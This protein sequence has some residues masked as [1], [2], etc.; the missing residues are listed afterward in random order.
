MPS[1]FPGMDPYVERP[2]I[3]PDFHD[4]L[5]VAIR[6]A[7]NPLLRP[8]YAALSR[9]RL[10]VIDS[11]R[12]VYPDVGFVELS[13]TRASGR[14]ATLEVDAPA[15]FDLSPEEVRE[16]YIE[17]IEP[18]AGNR[19]V[20]SIEVLSP[21]NKTIGDGRDSYLKKRSELWAADVNLVEIDLLRDGEPTIWVS[22]RRLD[23]LRPWHYVIAVSR[24]ERHKQEVYARPLKR[25]LPKVSIPLAAEDKDVILDLQA[26]FTRCWDEGAYPE[27]LRYR[28][29]PPGTLSADDLAWCAGIT[30]SCREL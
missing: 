16:P 30:Q 2:E 14:T 4:S 3:W 22:P 27:L 10:Y 23:T 8:R 20:T 24:R 19:I 21:T 7:L 28:E 17:I 5:I 12:P 26:A 1:P 11:Q 18:A 29:S 9:D 25:P 6:G 15:I 13:Q